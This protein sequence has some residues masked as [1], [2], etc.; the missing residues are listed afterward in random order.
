MKFWSMTA[1]ERG[2][3]A[4]KVHVLVGSM[5]IE[6]DTTTVSPPPER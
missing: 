1:R 4:R 3:F 2:L 5:R 6:M